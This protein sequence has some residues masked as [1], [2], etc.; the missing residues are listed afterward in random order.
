MSTEK[1]RYI[2]IPL[3]EDSFETAYVFIEQWMKKNRID[4]RKIMEAKLLFEAL[5]RNLADQGFDSDTVLRIK[6]QKT[7]GEI[8]IKLGFEGK[9][10]V[11]IDTGED[12]FSPEIKIVQAYNDKISYRY[13][14]G[15]NSIRIVVKRNYRRSLLQ[16]IIGILLAVLVYIPIL[17]NT[18]PGDRTVLN[19][20]VAIPLMKQFA[21]AM[22][23]VGAPVTFFSLVKNLTDIYIISEKSSSGRKLQMKTISTSAIAILLALGISFLVA[24]LL[25]SREGYLGGKGAVTG[26][27]SVSE[28]I[29][30]MIPSSIFEPFETYTPF[31]IIIVALLLTYALC[32]VGEYF[33]YMQRIVNACFTL[34]SRM[35]NVVM[36]TLPFFCFLSILS[37]LLRDGFANLLIIVE[38]VGLVIV[39]LI[40]IAVFYLI[41]L[42]IG[43]VRIGAFVRGLPP[44][45][46]ENFKINS[47]IDAVPFNIR[48]CVRKFGYSRQRLSENLPILAQTNQDGNC[49]LITLISMIFVFLLGVEVS[50]MHIVAIAVLVLFLSVGAP[51][52][53][54]SMLIGILIITFFLKADQLISIA[55]YAEVFF[56]ALQN[57]INV[58]GDIVT[59]AIEERKHELRRAA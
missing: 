6:P 53:P 1:S 52:Q 34:F 9:S 19:Q 48:Y 39:S 31:P 30:T 54:G 18:S 51:N 10:Y 49:Y 45:V 50:W 43:G 28:F 36:F 58:I 13:R 33:N 35:L 56:G 38:F 47:A 3:N 21:N 55:I 44:M 27:L 59:V 8:N 29:Y 42:L 11:P 20:N 12:D 4:D 23:M 5:F 17:L 37:A 25:N 57:I 32:S 41:R 14:M 46:W 24:V 16:C 15:Y 22:L 2:E 26:S 40:V 7:F